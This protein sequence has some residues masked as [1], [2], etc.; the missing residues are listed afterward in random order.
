MKI[1][2]RRV[3]NARLQLQPNRISLRLFSGNRITCD[4]LPDLLSKLMEKHMII[5]W[6]LDLVYYVVDLIDA[7][8]H[9]NGFEYEL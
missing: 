7:L 5:R 2:H 8:L 4:L 6:F 1:T 3:K 9:I